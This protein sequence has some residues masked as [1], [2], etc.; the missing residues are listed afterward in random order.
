MRPLIIVLGIRE[1][2]KPREKTGRDKTLKGKALGQK[3]AFK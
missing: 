3:H 2:F 1:G